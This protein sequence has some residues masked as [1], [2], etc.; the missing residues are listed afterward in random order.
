ME[1][2]SC[3][4]CGVLFHHV[5]GA[6]LCQ[7]CKKKVEED[8]Q[9]V[10]EYLYEYPGAAM[11]TVCEELDVTVRQ[12][13]QYLREGRLSVTIDSPIGLE[14]ERCKVRIITGRYCDNCIAAMSNQFSTTAKGMERKSISKDEHKNR[15]RYLDS[16]KLKRRG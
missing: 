4:R 2:K 13:K 5:V 8:F 7:K 15:M 14:C 6:P 3:K 9:R 1:V 10:K 11:A 16:G 12:V